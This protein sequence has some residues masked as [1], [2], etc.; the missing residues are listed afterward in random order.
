M[1]EPVRL[2][3]R[4]RSCGDRRGCRRWSRSCW[5][6]CRRGSCLRSTATTAA[7]VTTTT[8]AATAAV[9]ATTTTTRR[10]RR[11][12]SEGCNL[13]RNVVGAGINHP[14][15]VL[16]IPVH[17]EK[18]RSTGC[19]VGTEVT[20]PGALYRV[21]FLRQ[22]RA[23]NYSE[24]HQASH[25]QSHNPHLNPPYRVGQ[26]HRFYRVSSSMPQG[27]SKRHS[28]QEQSPG[29]PMGLSGP[30]NCFCGPS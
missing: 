23:R 20:E 9:T 15:N 29:R 19:F 24:H 16:H 27:Y 4:C 22:C 28:S 10:S 14:G 3:G 26:K 6:G 30:P 7:A 17:D 1:N 8:T 25:Y 5:G 13:Y 11:R 2:D 21:S 18:H 12:R